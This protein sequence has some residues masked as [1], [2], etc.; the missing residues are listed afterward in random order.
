MFAFCLLG[1]CHDGNVDPNIFI[2]IKDC[3]P[4]RDPLVTLSNTNGFS[5]TADRLGGHTLNICFW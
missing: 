4:G 5:T 3:I 2:L 1:R